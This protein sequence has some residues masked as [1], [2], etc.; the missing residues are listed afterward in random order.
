MH[1]TILSTSLHLLSIDC[2]LCLSRGLYVSLVI[3]FFFFTL[4]ELYFKTSVI[5]Y[6][7]SFV[8]NIKKFKQMY[9]FW[10]DRNALI[11]ALS[12]NPEFLKNKVSVFL[13]VQEF[14][15]Y[16]IASHGR[17]SNYSIMDMFSGFWIKLYQGPGPVLDII[18]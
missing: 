7:F 12:T 9:S 2:D 16:S 1:A 11:E 10:Q 5:H 3:A 15:L 13:H 17:L 4:E 14:L 18:S 8:K 6:L